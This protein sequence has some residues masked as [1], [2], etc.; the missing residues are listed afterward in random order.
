MRTRETV[1]KRKSRTQTSVF[2]LA[3]GPLSCSQEAPAT[4]SSQSDE[5]ESQLIEQCP[6]NK[7][8]NKIIQNRRKWRNKMEKLHEKPPMSSQE[9]KGRWPP[10][11]IHFFPAA[12]AAFK[13]AS[14]HRRYSPHVVTAAVFCCF[15]SVSAPA[16]SSEVSCLQPLKV[17]IALPRPSLLTCE[18]AAQ[19]PPVVD[20]SAPG[21]SVS[22]FKD[23]KCTGPTLYQAGSTVGTVWNHDNIWTQQSHRKVT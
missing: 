8:R 6:G 3:K 14:N 1:K 9:T 11:M 22:V 21:K 5:V 15:A 18:T 12:L 2:Q 13:S 16:F 23:T 19:I 17:T 7:E 4:Q 20:S 10:A